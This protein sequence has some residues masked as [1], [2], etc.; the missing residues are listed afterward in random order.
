MEIGPTD[1][2]EVVATYRATVIGILMNRELT[3]GQLANLLRELSQERFRPPGAQSTRTYS[4][5]T[6]E[7]WLYRFRASGLDGLRPQPRSDRGLD[8]KSVV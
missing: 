2:A 6:L 5:A 1:H 4:V 8:R 7:R 3:H